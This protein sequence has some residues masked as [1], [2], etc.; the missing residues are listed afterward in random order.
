MN[1]SEEIA[2]RM[3]ISLADADESARI[4]GIRDAMI[5]MELTKRSVL[6]T[7]LVDE[8]FIPD[9]LAAFKCR[10]EN[11]IISQERADN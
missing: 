6:I 9:A 7:F 5:S 2:A 4:A 11:E 8:D 3:P 1:I 10:V